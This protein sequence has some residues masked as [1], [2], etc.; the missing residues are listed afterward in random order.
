[1]LVSSPSVITNNLLWRR[2]G[3]SLSNAL[4]ANFSASI[5]AIDPKANPVLNAVLTAADQQGISIFSGWR[6]RRAIRSG[7]HCPTRG[8]LEIYSAAAVH[9]CRFSR[10]APAGV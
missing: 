1:M 9:A 5:A 4:I 3:P 2:F 10:I 6:C 7:C 8:S